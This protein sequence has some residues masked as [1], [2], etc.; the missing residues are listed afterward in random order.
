[1]VDYAWPELMQ[2]WNT[3]LL[4]DAQIREMLEPDV[5]ASGWLGFPG[6]TPEEIAAAETRLGTRLPDSYRQFLTFSNGW[7]WITP[8]IE[9]LWS[10]SEIERYATRHQ[11]LIEA[12]RLGARQYP[13]SSRVPDGR[14]F[15]YG[16][17]QDPISMRD[18]YLDAAIEISDMAD[19]ILLLNPEVISDD[20]EWEAWFFAAWL[21][22]ASRYRSFWDLMRGERD[23]YHSLR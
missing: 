6:A 5:V 7:R 11:D 17:E 15:V 2:P 16:A 3:E 8:F 13:T 18:E 20:G 12:W 4:A 19:G 14:Y 10:T 23:R 1:V 9:Q 22:G 21:P